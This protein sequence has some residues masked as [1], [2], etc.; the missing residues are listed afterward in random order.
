MLIQVST[1]SVRRFDRKD[2]G[3][4]AMLHTSNIRMAYKIGSLGAVG[5]IG[6]LLVGAIYFVGS[7]TQTR[8]QTR[9]RRQRR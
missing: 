4:P 2:P 9:R 5:I 3:L 7:A 6:L 8:Y 1:I